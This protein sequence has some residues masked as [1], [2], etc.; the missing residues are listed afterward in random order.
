MGPSLG[1]VGVALTAAFL[2]TTALVLY[3]LVILEPHFGIAP[4]VVQFIFILTAFVM[5]F[6]AVILYLKLANLVREIFR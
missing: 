3:L 5:F 6:V 2:T 1:I 4:Y